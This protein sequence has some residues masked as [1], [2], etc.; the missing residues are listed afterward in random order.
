MIYLLEFLVLVAAALLVA[1]SPV[2]VN[3]L[4]RF[5]SSYGVSNAAMSNAASSDR[6]EMRDEIRRVTD[7]LES[8][9]LDV[10]NAAGHTFR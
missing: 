10:R 3:L 9:N 2:L 4:E 8:K 7:I 6:A 1:A 5:F